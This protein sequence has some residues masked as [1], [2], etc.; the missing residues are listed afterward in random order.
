MR[1]GRGGEWLDH[2]SQEHRRERGLDLGSL[3]CRREF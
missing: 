3:H 2:V 1:H